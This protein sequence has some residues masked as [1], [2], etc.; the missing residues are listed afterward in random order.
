MLAIRKALFSAVIVATSV[1]VPAQ[2][3][4]GA[5]GGNFVGTWGSFNR[6]E[7]AMQTAFPVPVT[8]LT[9]IVAV[10]GGLWHVLALAR[11][12]S[13]WAWGHNGENELGDGTIENR[14]VPVRVH[15]LTN[16]VAIS[17]GHTHNLAAKS[18]GTVW[19]WGGDLPLPPSTVRA[20]NDPIPV[21]VSGLSDV[22]AVA[23]GGP[24][25]HG[26]ALKRDGTVLA[27]GSNS[28][29]QLGDGTTVNR[30]VAVQTVG[31]TGVTALAT[32]GDASVALTG[33]GRVWTWGPQLGDGT[34]RDNLVPVP[35]SGV[36]G[37]TSVAARAHVLAVKNDGTV[38]AWGSNY[39]GQ[40]GDG[41]T[42]H[43]N[44]PVPVAGLSG[45]KSAAVGASHSLAVKNDGTVWSWGSNG[46]GGSGT[47]STRS[48]T[49]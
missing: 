40:L 14:T 12:G 23:G 48:T 2:P 1:M 27:W 35:V 8:G 49:T 24:P 10:S 46:L 32:G 37:V 41:T 9:D 22:V 20:L 16:V 18:D 42:T 31:L 47:P 6:S 15:G 29:G 44:A 4:Q 45:V 38:W 39:T 28:R 21:Q 26:L 34:L 13:V 19:T 11:D 5:A 33:D 30:P 7:I 36:S 25:A 3:S 17:S 43:R